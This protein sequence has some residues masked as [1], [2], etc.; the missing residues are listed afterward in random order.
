MTREDISPK[1]MIQEIRDNNSTGNNSNFAV[2]MH[3]ILEESGSVSTSN[4][5]SED[6]NVWSYN[7][8]ADVAID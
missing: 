6:I 3:F 8:N 7:M 2:I 1:K 4:W 5:S